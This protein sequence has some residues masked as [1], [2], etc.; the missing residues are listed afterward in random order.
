MSTSPVIKT[1]L[2]SHYFLSLKMTGTRASL[3]G[4]E[5][6]ETW[7]PSEGRWRG[8]ETQPL[9]Q[10]AGVPL[11]CFPQRLNGNRVWHLCPYDQEIWA[12]L[13]SNRR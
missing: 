1:A 3:F 8:R 6:Q 5:T 4:A 11:S 13:N 7:G 9:S 2:G 10:R 12:T